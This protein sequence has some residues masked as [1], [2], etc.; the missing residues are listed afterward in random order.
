MVLVA[1]LIGI[2]L[3]SAVALIAVK[4][5]GSKKENEVQQEAPAADPIPQARRGRVCFVLTV[6]LI[7]NW[8]CGQWK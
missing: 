4:F 5:L 2:V 1:A 8:T 3:L 6:E 7:H